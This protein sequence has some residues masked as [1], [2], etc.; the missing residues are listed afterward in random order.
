MGSTPCTSGTNLLKFDYILQV[1]ALLL[2]ECLF[3]P[4]TIELV[5]SNVPMQSCNRLGVTCF[6]IVDFILQVFNI[7]LELINN[8]E[9]L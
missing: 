5:P 9:I 1:L 4:L 3:E 7:A 2:L 8:L 6:D